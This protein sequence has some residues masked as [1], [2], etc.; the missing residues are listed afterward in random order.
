VTFAD[1]LIKRRSL[2]AALPA[3][4]AR[5]SMNRASSFSRLFQT[6][7]RGQGGS[8]SH[9]ATTVKLVQRQSDPQRSSTESS[10][11]SERSLV[12]MTA[13]FRKVSG[14]RSTDDDA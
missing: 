4:V 12:E 1:D 10:S 14:R 3:G 6:K 8:T 2:P 9:T 13:V 7:Q 5:P 11:S